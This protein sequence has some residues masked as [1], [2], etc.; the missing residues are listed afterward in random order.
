MTASHPLAGLSIVVTRPLDQAGQL[1]QGIKQAG[2]DVILFPLLEI[3]PVSDQTQLRRLIACLHEFDL[4][5]FISRNAVLYGMAAIRA[6]GALP[7][8]LRIATV[9]QESAHALRKLGVAEV[10][11]PV[12]RSDSESLLALPELQ[13]VKGWRIAIFRGDGGRALLG[14]TLKAHGAQVEYIA[15]Y[16]RSK[17]M[18]DI[19][20]LLDANADALTVTSSEAFAYLWELLDDT[21]RTRLAT[22]PLFVP[23]DRI[24]S[25]AQ[26]FG[27]HNIIVTAGGDEGLLAGLIAWSGNRAAIRKAAG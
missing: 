13:N 6:A 10:I 7:K 19:N 23:H 26:S 24:A 1:T 12:G 27:W 16:R 5:I 11:A 9:G 20:M 2:G 3:S 14:D 15:C 4:A 25:V 21:S 22:V 18:Q 8:S 17:P